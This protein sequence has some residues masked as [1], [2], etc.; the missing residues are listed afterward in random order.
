MTY[1]HPKISVIV[2]VYN[3]EQYLPRC[4]DSILDQTFTDFELLL[5][6]DGSKDNSGKICDEYAAKDSR[7]RVFHKENG[8]VSS[9]R[10]MGLDNALGKWVTFVDSDD[11]I[12]PKG[13]EL[14]KNAS[15]ADIIIGEI[16]FEKDGTTSFLS[17][18][19]N[20]TGKDLYELVSTQIDHS[21]FCSPCAKLFSAN[22]IRQ[23]HIRFNQSLTFGEDSVFV[24]NYLLYIK[25]LSNIHELCYHYN[26]IGD[27]IYEKY[28]RSFR[29]ILDY[30]DEM[31]SLYDRFEEAKMVSI[32]KH[33]IIGVVF[34]IACICL[35]NN[36]RKDLKY[37]RSFLKKG[38]V[39][40]ELHKRG[41][42]HINMLLY[43][44][45]LPKGYLLLF[46]SKLTN[47]IKSF[48]Q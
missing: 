16:L 40:K 15:E 12:E 42:T 25:S 18:T 34:N 44:A 7:I 45:S 19:S 36:G 3:T 2:P 23:H 38:E 47:I 27:N 20:K 35:N 14:L 39:Q 1:N 30:Y 13:L 5:I 21:A 6:D 41:S 22:L 26:D 28:S 9:A 29:P 4:I 8:G 48:L 31:V 32:S 11:W 17:N 43:L 24:K 33:G 10:N 46:Y 37:I